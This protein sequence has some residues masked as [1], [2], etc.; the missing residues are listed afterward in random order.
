MLSTGT[1]LRAGAGRCAAPGRID[2]VK[3]CHP[4]AMMVVLAGTTLLTS[5]NAQASGYFLKDQS[6]SGQGAA[7]AGATA[8]AT[9][10]ATALFFNPAGMAV[11]KGNEV[12]GVATGIMVNAKTDNARA[13]RATRLGGGA[14]SGSTSSG[15]AGQDAVIPAGYAVYTVSPEMKLGLAITAP[16]GLI[17]HYDETWAGRY[18]GIHSSLRTVNIQPTLSYEVSPGLTLGAGAQIQYARARLTQGVDY[19][20]ILAGLGAPVRP[21]SLDGYGEVRGDSWAFG[22]TAGILYEPNPG[23][24]IGLSWRSPVYHKLSGEGKFQGVPAALRASFADGGASATVSTPDIISAGLYHEVNAS[25]AVMADVQ[26]TNW[27][28]FQELRINY[29]NP[30][31]GDTVTDERWRD[32]WLFSVGTQYKVNDKLTLRAGVALD[33]APTPD[34][35]R[36]PRIPDADRYWVAVGAGYQVTDT[37]RVDVGYTHLFIKNQ[38]VDLHDNLTGN[39]AFRGNFRADYKGSADVFAVQTKITF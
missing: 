24:R 38:K 16:W 19:G 37:M 5:F 35:T 7:F 21:G 11:V 20:S 29:D 33:K 25:W 10:D 31:R 13:T 4:V 22:G 15:D 28:R 36:T 12:V 34:S 2:P 30:L 26:W 6:A 9:G 3:S 1:V 18:H 39:D 32:A 17:S 14:I 27:S 8:G 23:T